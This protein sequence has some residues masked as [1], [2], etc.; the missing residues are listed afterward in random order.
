MGLACSTAVG[1][2][3]TAASASPNGGGRG[4]VINQVT[5]ARDSIGSAPTRF[6]WTPVPGADHYA[7]GVW[8]EVDQLLWRED[9]ILTTSVTAPETVKLEPGTYFWSVSALR[10]GQQL[11]ESGLAAFMVRTTP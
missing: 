8:N 6:T 2:R 4:T 11:A 9:N 3:D 7:I 1:R 10:E 5:P